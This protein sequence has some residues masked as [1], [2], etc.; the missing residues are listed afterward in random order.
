MVAENT[1]WRHIKKNVNIDSFTDCVGLNRSEL[2][3]TDS[4]ATFYSYKDN[5]NFA[6][7][8]GNSVFVLDEA[9]NGYSRF[10]DVI[11]PLDEILGAVRKKTANFITESTDT[12]FKINYNGLVYRKKEGIKPQ[13][14]EFVGI[15]DNYDKR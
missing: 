1:G 7:T 13:M 14:Y 15:A 9:G 11:I 5:K 4:R 12:K 2:L 3:L 6:F 10:N 8:Y